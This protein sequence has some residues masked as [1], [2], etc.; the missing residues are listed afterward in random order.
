MK[1]NMKEIN[2]DTLKYCGNKPAGK[3]I[4]ELSNKVLLFDENVNIQL[5]SFMTMYS[6]T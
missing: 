6:K 4:E 2:F 1:K 3:V 5:M